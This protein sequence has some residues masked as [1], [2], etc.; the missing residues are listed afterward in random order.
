M[1]ASSNGDGI[2]PRSAAGGSMSLFTYFR[3]VAGKILHRSEFDEDVAD[4]LRA[5]IQHRADDLQRSGLSS[6][7]AQ[8]RARLEFG[9]PERFKE[10]CGEAVGGNFLDTFVQDVRVSLR[11]LR[12]SPGFAMIAILTLALAIGANAVVFSVINA[13]LLHPLHVPQADSLYQLERGK[14]KAGN[15]SYPDYLDLRDRNQSFDGIAG[16]DVGAAGLDTGKEPSRVWVELATANYFEVLRVQPYLGRFFH[17]VDEHGPNSA[18][19]I[20]LTYSF[21]HTNFHDDRAV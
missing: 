12:K 13:F 2:G 21:W 5:H 4:E 15:F 6:A 20:V 3:S 10:E 1:A 18:P 14:D 11:V 17:P 16:Y 9:A 19:Y 8:R 7:E